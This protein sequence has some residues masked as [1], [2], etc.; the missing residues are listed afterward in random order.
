[1]AVL[2]SV[3][4]DKALERKLQRLIGPELFRVVKSS[5]NKAM[6]PVRAT[7]R[8]R[9]AVDTG[10]T[11]KAITRKQVVYKAEGNV[12]TMVGVRRSTKKTREKGQ[13]GSNLEYLIERG[14]TIERQDGGTTFVRP[15]P[16]MG[17]AWKEN[18]NKIQTIYARAIETG[19]HREAKR[20]G[21]K[22]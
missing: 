3:T 16:F 11:K 9:V 5:S 22:A 17:P 13:A 10:I 6:T 7:A 1:M 4:G 20:G 19:I 14:R 8:K 15:R 12:V 2:A 18:K 21:F